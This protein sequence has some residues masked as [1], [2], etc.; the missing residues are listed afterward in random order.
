MLPDA[1]ISWRTL[2]PFLVEFAKSLIRLVWLRH[3][4]RRH[5]V[6]SISDSGLGA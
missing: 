2:G 1:A 3:L 5:F 6:F 4:V